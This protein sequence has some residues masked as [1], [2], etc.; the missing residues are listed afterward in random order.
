MTTKAGVLAY[1]AAIKT[2]PQIR[3][4]RPDGVRRTDEASKQGQPESMQ[5]LCQDRGVSANGWA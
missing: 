3:V 4:T 1:L 5:K 2:N